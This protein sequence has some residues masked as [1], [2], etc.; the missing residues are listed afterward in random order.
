MPAEDVNVGDIY[1]PWIRSPSLPGPLRKP[2]ACAW[3]SSP[4]AAQANTSSVNSFHPPPHTF[5]N[6]MRLTEAP[7]KVMAAQ[8]PVGSTAPRESSLA[9]F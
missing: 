6:K 8:R 5:I 2:R 7:Y 9:I 4:Y 1:R 3:N